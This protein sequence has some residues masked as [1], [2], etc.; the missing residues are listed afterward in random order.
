[1][2]RLRILETNI[3]HA[4]DVI[5]WLDGSTAPEEGDMLRLRQP[6]A[7]DFS[8]KPA[9]VTAL[10]GAGR[11]A[12]LRRAVDTLVDGEA[13]DTAKAFPAAVLYTVAGAAEDPSG[14]Y[15]P[16]RFA[17][18]VG[19][20]SGHSLVLYP[21]PLATRFGR[22]GGLYGT[23][24][25]DATEGSAV[26]ALLT[27][28]VTTALGTVR[29]FRAQSDARGDFRLALNRLPP[30]PE[31]IDSYAAELAVAADES[32]RADSPATPDDFSV[33]GLGDLE[34]PDSFANP[35]R[36]DIQPGEVRL[37]RSANRDHLA[38]QPL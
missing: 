34:A 4:S 27:L 30:L 10:H 16:R 12:L 2:K 28:R 13:D 19:D 7:I 11:T 26:W 33:M 5:Y 22:A 38:V 1:M 37:L 29:T 15:V 35:L 32:A 9:D 3:L 20:A 36:L 14:R 21:T 25:F 18:D 23:L 17:I 8:S 6:V 31:G 24:R